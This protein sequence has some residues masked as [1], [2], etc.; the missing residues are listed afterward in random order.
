MMDYS[1]CFAS[2][3]SSSV[4]PKLSCKNVYSRFLGESINNNGCFFKRFASDL[5]SNKIGNRKLIKHGV[6]YAVAT[7]KNPNE[8]M[9]C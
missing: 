7:S 8:A 4:L 5:N 3:K 6:V 1:H 2:G 9:V